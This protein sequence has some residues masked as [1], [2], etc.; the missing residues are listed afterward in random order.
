MTDNGN[1]PATGDNQ[2][3]SEIRTV[4]QL[5]AVLDGIP[6]DTPLIVSAADPRDSGFI[7]EQVITSAGFG[8]INW[9]DGYGLEQDKVFGL[10]CRVASFS[11]LDGMR[12]HP[13]R[14]RIQPE[15]VSQ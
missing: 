8:W 6:D 5:R 14:P 11:E 4:G 12:K 1:T 3:L 15:E 13:V 9:G 10:N 7:D 2:G